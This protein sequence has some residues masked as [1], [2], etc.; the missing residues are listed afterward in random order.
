MNYGELK[1]LIANYL[2]RDDLTSTIPT[3]VTL[4]QAR[5]NHDIDLTS[6]QTT[7]TL[8]VT[9]GTTTVAL[10]SDFL[11]LLSIRIPY[12][13]GKRTL[14][15]RSLVQNSQIYESAGGS[16]AAPTYYARYGSTLELSPTPEADTTLEIVYKQKLAAFSADGDTDTLLTDNPNAYLYASLLEAALYIVD[17][18]LSNAAKGYYDIEIA[19]LIDLNDKAEWSGAPIEQFNLGMDTP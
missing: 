2:H 19:R 17:S 1:T 16:T 7:D 14:Q 3:F 4:A 13:G 15:Q 8:T 9:A 6:M 10:P 11:E 18:D 12:S 5:L